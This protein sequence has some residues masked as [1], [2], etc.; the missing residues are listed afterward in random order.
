[1]F[2]WTLDF[3]E[4]TPSTP[5]TLTLTVTHGNDSMT[6]VQ[7]F[8][9]ARFAG[10]VATRPEL[11]EQLRSGDRQAARTALL[12]LARSVITEAHESARKNLAAA[13]DQI[14]EAIGKHLDDVTGMLDSL[15][16]AM[17]QCCGPLVQEA[18]DGKLS[19]QVVLS[20]E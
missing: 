13:R 10:A 11:L 7:D 12:T 16:P 18:L 6:A 2:R 14:R 8:V 1:M 3:T 4:P 5:A 17:E 15:K 9:R 19:R 20:G